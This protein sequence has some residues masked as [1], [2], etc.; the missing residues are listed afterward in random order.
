MTRS[1]SEI[2]GSS[3]LVWSLAELL[4]GDYKQAEYGRVILP[5]VVLRRLDQERTASGT[6]ASAGISFA[7]LGA[8]EPPEELAA[9]LRAHI[10]ASSPTLREAMERFEFDRQIDRL[11]RAGLLA[12][13]VG[14]VTA[15]DL[16]PKRLNSLEMGYLF[17]EL[18]RRFAEQSNETAGEH[19]TPREV[20]R[21]MVA[22][23]LGD[24]ETLR[25]GASSVSVYDCSCGSGGML[26]EAQNQL[27]LGEGSGTELF[28]QELNQESYAVCL[29]DML[30]KG[31]D[32]GNIRLGNTLAED[33]HSGRQFDYCIANPPFGV[34]WSKV[35]DQVRAE[36]A[37]GE[38]GRF[39]AGLPRKSDG[40]L[41]FL[42]H[43]ISKLKPAAEGGGRIAI[44]HNSSP[45]F[46]GGA[47]TGESNI[48]RYVIEEDL[49]EA[50]VALPEQLFYNTGIASFVWI[51]TN[52][53]SAVRRGK[54]QLIDGRD[55]CVR[56][57]RSLGEK[58]REMKGEHIDEILSCYR[59]FAP[60]PR[61]QILD[62]VQ[63]GY[64][65]ITIERPLRGCWELRPE[66]WDRIERDPG[67]RALD[68]GQREV[69]VE[70][71]AE[72]GTRRIDAEKEATDVVVAALTKALGNPSKSLIRAVLAR[73]FVRDPDAPALSDASDRPR[74][75][76]ILRDVFHLPLTESPEEY[77][78]HNVL[79]FA[80]DAWCP[81]PEGKVGYEIPFT[82]LFAERIAVRP[83]AEVLA[84]L[85]EAELEI[86]E[87]AQEVL[88]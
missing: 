25:R 10:A 50:V 19:F 27:E 82:R 29:A 83:T 18:I 54:V 77:M 15:V 87:L 37:K 42:L 33:L 88:Q 5:L 52:E 31:Q 86:H 14:R 46:S 74:P 51:L 40:Q 41:L 79:P 7:D 20:I 72:L 75:D 4:R 45:L 84:E 66:S 62:N 38:R 9:R 85:Q 22:L 69:V 60:G 30:V 81:D 65:A 73:A 36:H 71:L 1:E 58:R 34:D 26:S 57:R 64:R 8:G 6:R 44:V 17:E 53:K 47:G 21:L 43:L 3:A 76:P 80:P 48:R 70:R 55:L 12:S 61:S 24:K 16:S 78:R 11:V 68:E 2:Q 13:V 35:E 39:A 28:G 32:P 63:F 59:G 56:T 23:L 49:L 67:V